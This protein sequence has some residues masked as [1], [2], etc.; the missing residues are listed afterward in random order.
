MPPSPSA[1]CRHDP[2]NRPQAP[3]QRTRHRWAAGA[4]FRAR[5][6]LTTTPPMRVPSL[7]AGRGGPVRRGPAGPQGRGQRRAGTAGRCWLGKIRGRLSCEI[8]RLRHLGYRC[9]M[10]TISIAEPLQIISIVWIHSLVEAEMGPTRRILDDLVDLGQSGGLP[11]LEFAVA[12]R[13]GAVRPLGHAGG[14]S[15]AGP[16]ADLCT[17]TLTVTRMP[18]SISHRLK[19]GRRGRI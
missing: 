5:R 15:R 11:V 7:R 9:L 10:P 16:T 19:N 12:N 14:A 2:Q 13:Q 3:A 1:A 6:K 4:V 8:M 18:A 17:S